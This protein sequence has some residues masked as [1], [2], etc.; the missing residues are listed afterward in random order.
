VIIENVKERLAVQGMG[1]IPE[2]K[3]K[4]ALE[5]WNPSPE[6][7]I[8]NIIMF[9]QS[10]KEFLPF[11]DDMIATISLSDFPKGFDLIINGHLHWHNT[12]NLGQALFVI[13]GSTIITQMKNLESEKPKG[14]CLYDT[15][16]KKLDFAVLP[17][18]RKL[19][20]HK[21][22]F[23][24][25]TPEQI[26]KQILEIVEVDLKQNKSNLPP[27]IRL[28]LTGSLAKGYSLQ[29]ISF[30][31]LDEAFDG[32]AILS[33]SRDFQETAFKKKIEELRSLQKS[34]QSVAAR[35]LEILEKNLEEAGFGKAFDVQRIFQ[36]L[37]EGEN[38]KV[39]EILS[40]KK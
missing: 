36:L 28:K 26:K 13:P 39:I 10:I 7:D 16:T 37:E 3:A 35:G 22:K 29:D 6:R 12:Q 20:Y 32:K 27:L 1:G 11:E 8:P 21:L 25:E 30:S 14:I 4:E 33:V 15:E 18:Q 38:E 5:I 31:Y 19:F 34:K 9:H 23:A 40:G 17:N 2:K 24:G